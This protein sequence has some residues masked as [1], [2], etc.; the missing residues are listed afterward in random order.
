MGTY[1]AGPRSLA[2]HGGNRRLVLAPFVVGAKVVDWACMLILHPIDGP[3]VTVY[4]EYVGNAGSI[5]SPCTSGGMAG[6]ANGP[7]VPTLV[8]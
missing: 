5:T 1:A 7:K 6:G 2:T 3:N 8:Q 4:L